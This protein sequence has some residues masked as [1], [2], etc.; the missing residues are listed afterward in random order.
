MIGS[1]VIM[2]QEICTQNPVLDFS[3]DEIE[4]KIS[5]ADLDGPVDRTE[6][7]DVR[8]VGS[9]QLDAGGALLSLLRSWRDEG[10]EGTAVH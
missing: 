7:F 8:A 3:Y 2:G 5:P 6:A 1:Q 4:V 9:P 10:Y